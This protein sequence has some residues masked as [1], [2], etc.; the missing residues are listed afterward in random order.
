MS[1]NRPEN[2]NVS[3]H[4]TGDIK[5]QKRN[6]KKNGSRKG[7]FDFMKGQTEKLKLLNRIRCSETMYY[8]LRSFMQFRENKD[9]ELPNITRDV[10][11]Q[12]EAYLK[13]KGLKRNTSSFYMRNLRSAYNAAVEAGLTDDRQPFRK[14]YTGV[15]KTVKRAIGMSDIRR[16]QS[17]DLS[18]K[19]VLD[20]ARDI[21]LFSFYMRGMSFIDMSYLRKK[22][23]QGNHLTYRRRKTNQQL[24]IEIGKEARGIIRKYPNKSSYLL[25]IIRFENGTEREQYKKRMTMIN[26]HLKTIG[27]MASIKIPLTTY[28]MRHTW[29]SIARDKGFSLSI[30][31]AG[32]GHDNEVTTQ[33]YLKSISNA[34]I[35]LA[36]KS[37]LRD[38]SKADT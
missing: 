7:L 11:E 23:V 1:K 31:S 21:L 13:D 15:D 17:L 8:T 24:T 36:N 33:I 27:K 34:K 10:I 5:S 30:I 28:V 22:D 18:A 9:I 20:F 4:A 16:I 32:L 6:A 29:A 38:L 12:Y 3:N 26:R 25:P 35:D 14:V 19:P 37:I 2:K